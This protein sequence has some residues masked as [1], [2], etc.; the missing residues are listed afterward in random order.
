MG[1]GGGGGG[2]GSL[3]STFLCSSA[4]FDRTCFDTEEPSWIFEVLFFVL[5]GTFEVRG[6][7]RLSPGI[8]VSADLFQN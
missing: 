6:S 5:L 7:L 1:V 2:G 3:L 4:L 8:T